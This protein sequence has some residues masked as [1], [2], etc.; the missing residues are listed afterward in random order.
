M[1]KK[2]VLSVVL[3]LVVTGCTFPSQRRLIRLAR[4]AIEQ[5]QGLA[6]SITL[7]S[8]SA[9]VVY[10]GKSAACVTFSCT[11]TNEQGQRVRGSCAVWLHRIR[12]RWELERFDLIAEGP[13]AAPLSHN[14][15]P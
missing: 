9:S 8:E 15:S 1:L 11:F 4:E 10:P 13:A 5:S 7:E 2:F 6:R 14:P 3:V 12:Y